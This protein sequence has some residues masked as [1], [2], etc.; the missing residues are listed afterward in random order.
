MKSRGLTH[1]D[2]PFQLASGE[3][4]H[5]YIDGKLSV[6]RGSDLDLVSRAILELAHERGVEFD[7]V[8]GLTMGADALAHGIA[9]VGGKEWFTVRKVRKDHGTGSLV[10]GAGVKGSRVLLVEDIVT[11]GGSIA[12]ALDEIVKDG[13]SVVLAV[14]MVDRSGRTTA[15]LEARGVPFEPLLTWEDLGIDPVGKDGRI[16]A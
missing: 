16:P 4:S 8:G 7:T 12:K 9:L 13:G 11:T 14:A 1:R 5:D 15:L 3:M 2:E 6:S 10:E